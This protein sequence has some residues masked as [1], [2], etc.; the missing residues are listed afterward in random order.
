MGN[1]PGAEKRIAI[2][3]VRVK[4][5]ERVINIPVSSK[6]TSRWLINEVVRQS[7]A[8]DIMTLE[9]NISE[10]IDYGLTLHDR[11][12]ASLRH[13]DL[14]YA[15]Y[16]CIDAPRTSIDSFTPIKMIGKGGF[17]TVFLARKKNT[18]NLYA[19]KTIKKS[20][21]IREKRIPQLLAEK[22]IMKN[23]DH[24]FII[25]FF[26]ALQSKSQVHLV[27]EFCP[28]GE[29]FFH[30]Q[31]L[32]RLPENQAQFY[33]AEIVLALE[34]L[35]KNDIIYRDLKP[36]NILLDIDGHIRLIDFGLSKQGLGKQGV[37]SSFCGSP[38]YMSPEVLSGVSH[39]RAVDFY[40]LGAILYEILVGCPP[41]YS[42]SKTQMEWNIVNSAPEFP[43]ALSKNCRSLLSQLLQ[44]E[45]EGRLGFNRGIEEVKSHPWCRRID[46]KKILAKKRK[47]PIVP[48]CR[49]SNFPKEFCSA[50]ISEGFL[51]DGNE[52]Y[53]EFLENFECYEQSEKVEKK[54]NLSIATDF[55]EY[56]STNKSDD[57]H[58][59]LEDFSEQSY[60]YSN[61]IESE[62]AI[63][64]QEIPTFATRFL[65]DDSTNI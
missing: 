57:K 52:E 53:G 63:N 61:S 59:K 18:G 20:L 37:T 24:P 39:G 1:S 55:Q 10:V 44:K 4:T 26:M 32:H 49:E 36:E 47:P 40:G 19:I 25:K 7:T 21:L 3:I 65:G 5:K 38:E 45:P 42:R 12:L 50:D 6:C 41:F 27:M 58:A 34:Y 54:K 2:K 29:L 56:L 35:H 60:V 22:D 17:S 23:S 11:G 51:V 16:S 15:L 14:L 43:R 13:N 62:N 28:G 31:K 8:K 33:F 46:W 9:S 48:N 64:I 30:L